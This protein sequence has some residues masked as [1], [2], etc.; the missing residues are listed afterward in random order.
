MEGFAFAFDDM[1]RHLGQT[2]TIFT[3]SGGQ[4]GSGFTGV[5]ISV[6]RNVVRLLVDEGAPPACA[7]GSAC[8]GPGEGWGRGFGFGGGFGWGGFGGGFCNGG[9]E[10]INP[11]GAIAV[12]PCHTIAAFVHHAI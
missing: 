2:V 1:M 4:S 12:I 7:V 8:G 9:F 11:L 6:D 5:L 10:N 3:T